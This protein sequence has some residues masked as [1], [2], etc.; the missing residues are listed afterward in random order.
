MITDQ[1]ALLVAKRGF[2]ASPPVLGT[3][4]IGLARAISAGLLP[5][6]TIEN[7]SELDAD[8]YARA[9]A[10]WSVVDSVDGPIARLGVVDPPFINTGAEVWPQATCIFVAGPIDGVEQLL[11]VGDVTPF[12]L[13]IGD[14]VHLTNNRIEFAWKSRAE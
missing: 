12:E 8:G 11:W 3:C 4:T 13:G 5:D 6:A 9:E 10:I 2:V 7:L 14:A 1:F